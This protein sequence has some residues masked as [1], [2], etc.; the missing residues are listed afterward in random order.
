KYT[1]DVNHLS[2]ALDYIARTISKNFTTTWD[3]KGHV[4]GAALSAFA[5]QAYGRTVQALASVAFTLTQQNSDGSFLDAARGSSQKTL[6][7]GWVAIALEQVQ[8]GPLFGSFL[9]PFIFV[10]VLVVVGFDEVCASV[11]GLCW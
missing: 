9:C 6:D 4:H 7:T 5:F 1:A 8:P 3:H 10:G 2:K 11:G